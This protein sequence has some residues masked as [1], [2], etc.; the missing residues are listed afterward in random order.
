MK[1]VRARSKGGDFKSSYGFRG[2]LD[3][4]NEQRRR[5]QDE[6]PP[7]IVPALL[8]MMLYSPHGLGQVGLPLFLSLQPLPIALPTESLALIIFHS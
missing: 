6:M 4:Y 3:W 8:P 2:R 1:K 5:H 7:L